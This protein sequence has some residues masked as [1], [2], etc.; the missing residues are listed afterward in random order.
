MLYR[1][2]SY[3]ISKINQIEVTKTLVIFKVCTYIFIL[4]KIHFTNII[5]KVPTKPEFF[6]ALSKIKHKRLKS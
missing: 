2:K 3:L 4:H 5:Y 6:Q 1:Y